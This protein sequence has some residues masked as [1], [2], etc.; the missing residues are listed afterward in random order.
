MRRLP[1]AASGVT[2]I[3]KMKMRR[4]YYQIDWNK[5]EREHGRLRVGA[6]FVSDRHKRSQARQSMPR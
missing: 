4:D 1:Y 5:V 2:T 3:C 6:P